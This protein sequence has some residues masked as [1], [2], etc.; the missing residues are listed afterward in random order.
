ML[1]I[2]LPDTLPIIISTWGKG[3]VLDEYQIIYISKGEGVFESINCGQQIVKEG[4]I[5][6]LFPGEWHRF[7]P[8][9]QTGWDE[10]WVG[11]K[12]VI[13][14]NIA[15]QH[16]LA[17]ENAVLEIGLHEIIIQLFTNIIE[18]NKRRK[19]GLPAF[20]VRHCN[21]PSW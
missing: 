11:F 4:T 8:N 17:K 6:F 12:G 13:I 20:S 1:I 5:I 19:N 21:A 2:L 10:F 18:K 7:K 15:Q 3:R 9:P 14:E 16:F